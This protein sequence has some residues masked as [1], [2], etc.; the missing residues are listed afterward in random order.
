MSKRAGNVVVLADLVDAIGADAAR[1][2]LVRY[3]VEQTI[4]LDLDAWA[5]KT[6]DNPVYYVQYAHARLASLQ[7]NAA[8]LGIVRDDSAPTSPCSS[9]E[10]E[11]D[12]LAALAEFPRV[13]AAAAELRAPHRIAHYLESL[14][15]TYHRFYDACRVLPMGDEAGNA[16]HRTRGCGSAK[17]PA[18]CSPTALRLLGVT[19]PGA[20]VAHV[21][22]P[23]IRPVRGTPTCCPRHI[24]SSGAVRRQRARSRDLA[25]SARAHRR[26]AAL[27]RTRRH[28]TRRRRTARRRCCSTRTTCADAPGPTARR[29]PTSTSTTRAR[30]S[31]ARPSRAGSPKRASGLDVCTGG[32]L[33]VALAAGFPAER[34][35]VHGNNK[36]VAELERAVAARV[37]HVIVDSFD[38]IDRLAADRRRCRHPA[39]ASSSG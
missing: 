25:A 21:A 39:S 34:I 13:V 5:R 37:G 16:D 19:A 28:R 22:V 8:D 4:D 20:D 29:S 10:R 9:H 7:R 2:A 33:A 32:E 12:L 14:A 23:P 27:R 3:S 38:E 18:S 15:G 1:Y 6:N 35:A 26:R 31:C 11:V 36:S 30:R 24:T 17:P